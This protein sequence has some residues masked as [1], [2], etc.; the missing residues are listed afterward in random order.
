MTDQVLL[1]GFAGSLF[2]I[3]LFLELAFNKSIFLNENK[4]IDMV[5]RNIFMGVGFILIP[6]SFGILNKICVN[7]SIE[8]AI[9]TVF[10]ISIIICGGFV[11][12]TVIYGIFKIAPTLIQLT[13]KFLRNL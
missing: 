9:S 4:Y 6:F 3:V 10:I 7:T 13:N 11:L 1:M 5:Y 12:A 8:R 2:L